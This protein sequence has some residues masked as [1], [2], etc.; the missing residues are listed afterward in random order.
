MQKKI[1]AS[2]LII[3]PDG[4]IFHLHLKPEDIGRDI[5]LVGD[6][7]RVELISSLFDSIELRKAN[8]EFVSCTGTYNGKRLTVVATGIGTDN[9]D[10]VVNELDA[11]VNID[12]ETRTVK[13]EH[14]QLNFVRIGTSG[15]LQKDLPV[16]SW[17]LSEKAIGFDGLINFYARRNEISDL[18][19]EKAFTDELNWN[20]LLT[21]P[22][23]VDA[24]P[25]LL[26]KLDGGKV[27]R[28]VTISAPGFYGPQGRELRL[29]IADKYINAKITGFNYQ[30]YRVTNYE[31]ECSAIYGLSA[32]LGHQ[33]A[34][35]CVIIANRLA[36]T[37]TKDYKPVMKQLIEH[38]VKGLTQ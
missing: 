2:E 22:Y 34:T 37:A 16:D 35:V 28:G 25:S 19:F 33:A 31:M 24:A 18:A 14:T 12:F 21:A 17:L 11:L 6:P 7:G 4:S 36:G 38:V 29:D 15:A 9:I 1:E 30:D 13:P 27:V 26:H 32:L 5:I 20:P 23:V 3:N 8:R 10:I